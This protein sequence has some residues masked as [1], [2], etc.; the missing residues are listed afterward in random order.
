MV[1]DSTERLTLTIIEAA[2]LLGIS[3]NSCY[4][5]CARGELPVLVVGRRKLVPK[6]ALLDLLFRWGGNGLAPARGDS[7]EDDQKVGAA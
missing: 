6:Q 7:Q 4:E 2:R 1:A 5:A 3:K